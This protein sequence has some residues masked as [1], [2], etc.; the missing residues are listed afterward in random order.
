MVTTHRCKAGFNGP[1]RTIADFILKSD[2]DEVHE[3]TNSY[4][5][6]NLSEH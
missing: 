1:V 5:F 3:K 2:D 6:D 4:R